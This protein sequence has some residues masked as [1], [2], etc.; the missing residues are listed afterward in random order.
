MSGSSDDRNVNLLC[1][2]LSPRGRAAVSRLLCH[3]PPD[4]KPMRAHVLALAADAEATISSF[5][6]STIVYIIAKQWADLLSVYV[7]RLHRRPFC[8]GG[9]LLCGAEAPAWQ[10]YLFAAGLLLVLTPLQQ[11]AI[12]TGSLAS[13][14][15][16]AK[17]STL[18]K[19]QQVKG[20]VRAWSHGRVQLHLPRRLQIPQTTLN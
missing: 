6:N 15:Q 20:L 19:Q 1:P 11:T 10:M 9:D 2:V 16:M 13:T 4:G 7:F 18:N 17:L 3:W 14:C 8:E 12:R 5:L